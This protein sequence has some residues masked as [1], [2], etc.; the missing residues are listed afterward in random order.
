MEP[1][2]RGI[3]PR[4]LPGSRHSRNYA[5]KIQVTQVGSRT[6]ITLSPSGNTHS[7]ELRSNSEMLCD[8]GKNT[9]DGLCSHRIAVLLGIVPKMFETYLMT[10][11]G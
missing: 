8:C 3:P 1:M 4:K 9:P 10:D 5:R 11:K 7:V 2:K 6:W